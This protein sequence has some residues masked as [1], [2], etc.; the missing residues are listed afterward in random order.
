MLTTRRE[1]RISPPPDGGDASGA[2]AGRFW[3]LRVFCFR[4]LVGFAGFWSGPLVW[5]GFLGLSGWVRW[6]W[7]KWVAWADFYLTV[8]GSSCKSPPPDAVTLRGRIEE[9]LD[10]V[11]IEWKGCA[12]G[13]ALRVLL[14]VHAS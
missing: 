10:I 2:G 1:A 7:K 6:F 13:G 12:G 8:C 3:W 5:A 14:L 4:G 11:G 9:F